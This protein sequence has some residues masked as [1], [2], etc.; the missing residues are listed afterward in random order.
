[1]PDL[2]AAYRGLAAFHRAGAGWG[3]ALDAVAGH[4]PSWADAR[5]AVGAGR[6][7]SEA[8]A[9]NVPGLD[10]A[11]LRAGEASGR[12]EQS[13]EDLAE[14][15]TEEHRRRG[16][17]R[18]VLAYPFLLAHLAA[19]ML[20][21]P[22]LVRGHYGAAFGWALLPLVPVYGLLL[23]GWF[24]R[25]GAGPLPHR[26][27]WTNTVEEHD[28]QAL[29]ALG[30]LY[31]AGVPILEALP[32]ARNAG[33]RGRAAEDLV[34]AEARVREGLDVAGA[35]H[36]LP[37]TISGGLAIAERTGSLG[38]ECRAVATRL[39]FDVEMRRKR[40]AARLG[41]LMIVVLGAIVGLR[42]FGFYASALSQA[43]LHGR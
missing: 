9:P 22:D 31:D 11:L 37:G 6:T 12:L 28:A 42:V 25:R 20:P 24:T 13:L 32:L 27:P 1:V 36:A 33:P 17:R 30:T 3:Q 4:D 8:L 14:R 29:D 43:G 7:F 34:R 26:F 35:W 2:A 23:L 19:F 39:A 40:A 41:P 10:L 18:S 38:K 5:R 15:H 21:F 16:Q